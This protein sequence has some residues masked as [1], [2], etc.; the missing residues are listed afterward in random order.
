MKI[1][2]IDQNGDRI[3]IH[4]KGN[5]YANTYLIDRYCYELHNLINSILHNLFFFR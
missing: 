3:N 2:L 5:V 4:S 1:D